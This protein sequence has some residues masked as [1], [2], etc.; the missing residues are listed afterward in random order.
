MHDVNDKI[1][2]WLPSPM[3]DAILCTPALRAIRKRFDSSKV[4]FF[5]SGVVHQVLTPSSFAD[6]WLE[7]DGGGVFAAARMLRGHNFTHAILFKNSFGS[8]LACFLARIPARIGYTREGRGI[9]LTERLRPPRLSSGD[10]KPISMVDYYLAVAS[11]LGADVQDRRIELSIEPKDTETVKAKLPQIFSALGPVVILVPGAAA[12][13]SKRWPADRFAQ[14]ADRLITDYKATVVLSVAPNDEERHIAEQIVNAATHKLV[15]LGD[16][17]ISLGELK[18]LFAVSDLV[19]CNDTG[20]RH[21]AIGLQRNVITLVGP[22]D[23]TWTDPG[24]SDEVFIKGQ[25]PCAPCDKHVCTKPSHLCMEA[26]T[27]DMVCQAAARLLDGAPKQGV[28]EQQLTSESFFVKPAYKAGL[29]HLGLTSINAVFAFQAGI[30]LTK[31]NL[32]RHRSRIEFKIES[33]ATTVFLKRYNRPPISA[34]LKNWLSAKKRISCG[35]AEVDAAQNLSAMGINTP[36]MV[37]WGQQWGAILEKRSF[38]IIEEILGISLERSL[39]DFFN[40]AETPEKLMMRR[41]FIGQLAAFIRKFHDTGYRHRDLYL[42]HI[43][44]TLDDKFYL[45]DLAR[46]FKP[47]LLCALFLIKDIAQLHYSAP[48]KY[49]SRT[50]RLRFLRAYLG[51]DKL[52]GRDRTFARRINNKAKR[53]AHHDE[54]HGR[55]VPFTTYNTDRTKP[56]VAIII[57]RADVELGGAERS[58]SE[59]A[60]ALRAIDY[61]TH[62]LAAKG[63][64]GKENVHILCGDLPGKRTDYQ[65]FAEALKKHLEDNHY[66]ILHSVL[67]FDFADIYQPRSGTYA[68]TIIRKAATYRWPALRALKKWTSFLN[69]RRTVWFGAE[70]RLAGAQAGPL[71]IAISNY[72]AEQFK[73][74]YHTPQERIVVIPNGI[75]PAPKVEVSRINSVRANLLNQLGLKET[76]KPVLFFFAGHDFCRKGLDCLVQAMGRLQEINNR[77]PARLIIAGRA[78]TGAYRRLAKKLNVEDRILFLGA[79]NSVQDLIAATDVAVLPT[80][81]DPCSRFIL[82][83][84]AAGR[85]VIT[86]KFNGATDLFVDDRHGRVIDEPRNIVAISDALEHFTNQD[87]LRR[88][89]NAVIGDNLRENVSIARVAG[90]LRAVYDSILEKRRRQ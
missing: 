64:A 32:A 53:M 63:K 59:M 56:K 45:I 17:P 89:E 10:F 82:E 4:T 86:T 43:F 76:E 24:Y 75:K 27:V 40:G 26:I 48:A 20:P 77:T 58:V 1:L 19:I 83:A 87:N 78:N 80:F 22:N 66:D 68:E 60:E 29:Q 69:F 47:T 34:Q 13:P 85:P 51:R 18:A 21:I 25:V 81:D 57:E 39:P 3:G 37:A 79:V 8:A 35:F 15:N 73:T 30:N 31:D 11:W 67:P 42:C 50:D 70:R 44:R 2:V 28:T 9:L 72:V 7:L 12:G 84:L 33:P 74:H 16:T 23:P 61:D 46:A 5:G 54:K 88:A 14:T 38:V 52:D 71:I 62:I 41:R 36:R 49:F 65:D 6:D 90:Q 55:V